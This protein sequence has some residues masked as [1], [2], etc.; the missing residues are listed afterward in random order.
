MN[1]TDEWVVLIASQD[2]ESASVWEK[3]FLQKGC[4]V[5]CEVSPRHALQSARLVCPALIILDLDLPHPERLDLCRQLRS[6]T[7]GIILVMTSIKD[8]QEIYEYY[9]AG[10]DEHLVTPVNPMALLI[11]SLAWLV[12]QDWLEL[13]QV[14][15]S[16]VYK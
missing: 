8:E 5:V 7:Q 16:Q 12:K 11:K 2:A 9:V 1:P 14:Q 3:L 13:Q 6:V 15:S 10:A 4:C